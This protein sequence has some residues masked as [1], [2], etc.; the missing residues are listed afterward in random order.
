MVPL[1]Y[2]FALETN[3]SADQVLGDDNLRGIARELVK[4]VKAS[5]TMD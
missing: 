5:V 4:I 3:D 2:Y 1:W